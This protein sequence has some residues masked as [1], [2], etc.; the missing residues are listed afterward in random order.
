MVPW[1]IFIAP[2]VVIGCLKGR[3]LL[4]ILGSVL[5]LG[6]PAILA[7]SRLAREDSWW[8]RRFY[9]EEK[10]AHARERYSGDGLR[11]ALTL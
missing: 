3:Y 4:S 8:A 2:F 7:A 5:L 1:L 10:L 11:D 9:D 6:I